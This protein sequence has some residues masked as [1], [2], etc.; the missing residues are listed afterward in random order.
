MNASQY[1]N[2]SVNEC[3]FLFRLFL[4]SVRFQVTFLL[5]NSGAVNAL[6][7]NHS[8]KF[9]TFI[10]RKL[11]FNFTSPDVFHKYHKIYIYSSNTSTPFYKVSTGYMFR[12][13]WTIIRPYIWTGSL[14]KCILGS[15]TVTKM[16]LKY[17]VLLNILIIIIIIIIN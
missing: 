14:F 9:S 16:L 12:P 3:S 6:S 10:D 13:S 17:W 5:S 1:G 2:L 8:L 7:Q 11:V 4:S 15:Q